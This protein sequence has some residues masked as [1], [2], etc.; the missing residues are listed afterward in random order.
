MEKYGYQPKND[1][2]KQASEGSGCPRCGAELKGEPP[3]CP[4]CGS[5]PFERENGKEKSRD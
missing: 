1:K 3:V 5:K 2:S 4:N